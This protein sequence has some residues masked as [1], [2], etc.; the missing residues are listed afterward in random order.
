MINLQTSENTGPTTIYVTYTLQVG[1]TSVMFNRPFISL[2]GGPAITPA[3]H[4]DGAN[5]VMHLDQWQPMWLGHDG[6]V[7]VLPVN[8]STQDAAAAMARA[9][10]ADP[11]ISWTADEAT[12][13]A[14]CNRYIAELQPSAS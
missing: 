3:F 1:T 13:L 7:A 5:V 4:V 9:F 14:W 2:G 10:A 12:T 11:G 6:S 8:C